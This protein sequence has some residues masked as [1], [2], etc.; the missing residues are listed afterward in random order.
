VVQG[1][2]VPW[3]FNADAR[4]YAARVWGLLA[5]DPALHT[6]ALT[7]I[8][9]V[10][11]GRR[12]SDA[13]MLFGWY[14]D[15]QVDPAPILGAVF[16]TPPYEL[17]LAQVPEPTMPELVDALRAASVNVPGVAGEAGTVDHFAELWT[18]GA[19][20]APAMRQR[21]YQLGTLRPPSP[22]P[23]GEAH[24]AEPADLVLVANWYAAFQREAGA[25]PV[26]VEPIA[27]ETIEQ[28]LV[29]LWRNSAGAPVS[30]AARTQ[31]VAGVARIGPVYTPPAGRRRGYAA[32]VTAACTEAALRAG[33]SDVVL[34]TDLANPIPNKIYQRLGY[35]P[36]HD[37]HVVHF[38]PGPR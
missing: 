37:H 26:D 9:N 6:I 23:P 15:T 24:L 29:W 5:A 38:D 18:G 34:Y 12:W 25:V 8:D 19:G 10:L 30:L 35:L 11:A 1:E 21:L 33:A 14:E 32:A 13:D 20:V 2:G 27:R 28:R 36:K 3:R 7:V 22:P 16:R 17:L 4:T 31:V